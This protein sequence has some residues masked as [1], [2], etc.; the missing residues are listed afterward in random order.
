MSFLLPYHAQK[1]EQLKRK[2][3]NQ[4][5][6]AMAILCAHCRGSVTEKD[7]NVTC[8][9]MCNGI[10]HLGCASIK[11]TA[12]DEIQ[13]SNRSVGFHCKNCRENKVTYLTLLIQLK[14]D[15][16]K[17]MQIQGETQAQMDD[18]LN[19]TVKKLDK[20]MEKLETN[21]DVKFNSMEKKSDNIE[22]AVEESKTKLDTIKEKSDNIASKVEESSK[23]GSW[24][25]VVKKKK[26]QQVVVVKPKNKE[27][28][29]DETI[30][31]IKGAIKPRDFAVRRMQGAVK[32]GVIIECENDDDCTKLVTEVEKKLGEKYEVRKPK[33]LLPRVKL[34]RAEIYDTEDDEFLKSLGKLNKELGLNIDN[35]EVVKREEVKFFK[36]RKLRDRFNVVLQVSAE[37]YDKMMKQEVLSYGWGYS[38]VVDNVY[39]RRCY[40]CYGFNHIAA[41][42]KNKPICSKCGSEEHVKKDCKVKREKCHN[43]VVANDKLRKGL[44]VNHSVWSLECEVYKRKLEV[45]KRAI[46]Y[47]E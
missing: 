28:K 42:C 43:C 17:M 16:Q 39:I 14:D 30:S 18:K 22:I 2:Q 23:D 29:Q 6:A 5:P 10:F 37:L 40:N 36:G 47:V 26:K 7:M 33:N 38:R 31:S 8:V 15:M 24:V 46:N 1:L 20:R 11:K 45:S 19:E 27:Q 4:Q 12:Y 25:E 41:E 13:L 32:G 21:M 34:L 44:D 9:G 35:A 3:L